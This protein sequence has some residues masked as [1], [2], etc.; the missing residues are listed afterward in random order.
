MIKCEICG[1]NDIVKQDG[2][3]ICQSCGCKYSVEDVRKMMSNSTNE[4]QVNKDMERIKKLGDDAFANEVWTDAAKYYTELIE[5]YDVDYETEYRCLI[6]KVNINGNASNGFPSL[7]KSIHIAMNSFGKYRTALL[8]DNSISKEEKEKR[9]VYYLAEIRGSIRW[10]FDM[11][12]NRH[13]DYIEEENISVIFDKDNHIKL[14]NQVEESINFYNSFLEFEFN[15]LLG[16]PFLIEHFIETLDKISDVI[17]YYMPYCSKYS[18]SKTTIGSDIINER[19]KFLLDAEQIN[20]RLNSYKNLF[21][22]IEQTIDLL[23]SGKLAISEEQMNNLLDVPT[24]CVWRLFNGT[25]KAIVRH[26]KYILDIYVTNDNYLYY[27]NTITYDCFNLFL[28][29]FRLDMKHLSSHSYLIDILRK[30]IKSARSLLTW[31]DFTYTGY[32]PSCPCKSLSLNESNLDKVTSFKNFLD[33]CEDAIKKEVKRLNDIYWENHKDEK[34]QLEKEKTE[35]TNQLAL[36]KKNCDEQISKLTM[37]SESKIKFYE[38]EISNIQGKEDV[39]KYKSQINSNCIKIESLG[40]FKRKE[41]NALEDEN[42]QMRVKVRELQQNI[43]K[44]K[45]GIEREI[46]REKDN[47]KNMCQQLTEELQKESGTLEDR[48]KKI[49]DELT[50]E[51]WNTDKTEEA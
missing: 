14:L 32:C 29:L 18:G 5:K 45:N 17:Y 21:S 15:E 20:Y 12:K 8:A 7:S 39:E 13:V 2:V 10:L 50:K 38:Q 34:Q 9:C 31:C 42:S 16:C 28:D 47:L 44:Q 1:G 22:Y 3:F 6:A 11:E 4:P 27:I 25:K 26:N 48:L 19:D 36:L 30:H 24:S 37:G 40:I 49:D 35:L 33:E 23:N 41:K 46:S 51:R 43:D